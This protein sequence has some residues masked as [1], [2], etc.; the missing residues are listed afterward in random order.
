MSGITAVAC[1]CNATPTKATSCDG[2]VTARPAQN[3]TI[4]YT[5]S[6]QQRCAMT[7]YTDVPWLLC[8]GT[9]QANII[10][11]Q[12]PSCSPN[13]IVGGLSRKAAPVFGSGWSQ[14]TAAMLGYTNFADVTGSGCSRCS[15]SNFQAVADGSFVIP[16]GNTYS[17]TFTV[18]FPCGG[19]TGQ[20]YYYTDGDVTFAVTWECCV[21]CDCDSSS[22]VCSKVSISATYATTYNHNVTQY[23]SYGS[24][25][26]DPNGVAL[27]GSSGSASFSFT[28][29]LNITLERNIYTSQLPYYELSPGVYSKMT[30]NATNDLGNPLD[31]FGIYSGTL[32]CGTGVYSQDF[33]CADISAIQDAGW[34]LTVTAS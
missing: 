30:G 16:F 5:V 2:F 24:D 4:T 14:P 3:L 10:C 7:G 29:T 19:S 25:C 31:F 26:S 9:T 1:C 32:P 12:P 6:P 20:P 18:P 34:T 22:Y 27:Y 13:F 21:T 11:Y 23:Q 8:G 28:Q 17:G 33:T 15:A